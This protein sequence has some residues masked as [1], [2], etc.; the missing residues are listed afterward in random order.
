MAL[1]LRGKDKGKNIEIKQWC[2]DWFM[3]SNGKIVTP[4]TIQLTVEEIEKVLSHKNNG[5]LFSLYTLSIDGKFRRL[6]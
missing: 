3:L 6:K 4:S 2:N 1:I 5:I